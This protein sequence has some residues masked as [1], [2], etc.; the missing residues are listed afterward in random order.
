MTTG[1]SDNGSTTPSE[2]SA[3]PPQGRRWWNGPTSVTLAVAV[4]GAVAAALHSARRARHERGPR[5]AHL[6]G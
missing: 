4:V 2:P 6:P 3:R 5:R 1:S